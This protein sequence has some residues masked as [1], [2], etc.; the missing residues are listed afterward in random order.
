M[1]SVPRSVFGTGLQIRLACADRVLLLVLAGVPAGLF[2]L[3]PDS[4]TLER[5]WSSQKWRYAAYHP[6]CFGKRICPSVPTIPS[7]KNPSEYRP[8]AFPAPNMNRKSSLPMV[9]M[10]PAT[11][12]APP[13]AWSTT[14]GVL[15][16]A[17]ISLSNPETAIFP[18]EVLKTT[19]PVR[20]G[21]R[22]S[23]ARKFAPP[24]TVT[25]DSGFSSETDH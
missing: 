25:T 22:S 1:Y 16:S 8:I 24:G 19:C 21:K 14:I 23:S 20:S 15:E 17:R 12:T 5:N 2:S 6:H 13:Q 11:L 10:T 7:G 4:T 9:G 3:A 18:F